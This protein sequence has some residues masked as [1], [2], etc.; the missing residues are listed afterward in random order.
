VEERTK[1]LVKTGENVSNCAGLELGYGNPLMSQGESFPNIIYA[2]DVESNGCAPPEIIELS[3]LAIRDGNISWPPV[4]WTIKP[5]QPIRN[6]ATKI[7]GI[8]DAHVKDSP[9]LL[10]IRNDIFSILQCHPIIA[11]NARV[12]YNLLAGSL[13]NWRPSSVHDTLRL[14]RFV[15]PELASHSLSNLAAEFQIC[16]T[17]QRHS[18]TQPH[19]ASFDAA[20]AA[21][22][23][24]ALVGK[25]RQSGI[26]IDRALRISRLDL[27]DGNA[28][29]GRLL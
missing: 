2:V 29:Q 16:D 18:L 8:T 4:A 17:L 5:N 28:A 25:A 13:P 9:T 15:V 23:F 26:T 20:A 22:L 3:V 19:R 24:L 11:H 7:H 21:C 6:F 12:D 1:Q 27:D 14:A 10:A